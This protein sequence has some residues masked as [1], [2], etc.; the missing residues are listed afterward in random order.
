MRKKFEMIGAMI[1][2]SPIKMKPVLMKNVNTYARRGSSFGPDPLPKKLSPLKI[3]S[4]HT[5]WNVLGEPT[6]LASAEDRVAAKIPARTNGPTSE[7]RSM[8]F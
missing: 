8:T 7:K 2:S 5:A 6:K 3:P 1:F 4:R